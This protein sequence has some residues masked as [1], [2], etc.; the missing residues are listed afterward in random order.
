MSG[1]KPVVLST[2]IVY[3]NRYYRVRRDR[4]RNAD[5]HEHDYHVIEG[6][7]F[8]IVLAVRGSA[9]A[10][11]RQFRHTVQSVTT[12]LVK[13]ACETGEAP[14]AA[15]ARELLEE[16]GCVPSRPLESLGA[17]VSAIGHS[18]RRGHVLLAQDPAD[19]DGADR[20]DKTEGDLAV[21]W[22]P[23]EEFL[24]MIRAGEIIDSE[25]LAAWSLY[26]ASGQ[27]LK[28]P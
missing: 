3:E 24:A 2:E 17:I 12:E 26:A 18:G 7:P 8:V 21:E 1:Q 5:G 15:A 19:G 14:E 13:G 28:R 27:R 6:P 4:L 25:T 11:V 16:A 20:R 23:A 9:I 22:L 10:V